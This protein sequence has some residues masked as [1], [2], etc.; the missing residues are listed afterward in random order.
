MRCECLVSDIFGRMAEP[1]ACVTPPVN[2]GALPANTC[3]QESDRFYSMHDC[4]GIMGVSA[5]CGGKQ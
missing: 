5:C 2:P 4:N 1:V 3:T